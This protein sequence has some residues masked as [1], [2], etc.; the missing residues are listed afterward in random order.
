VLAHEGSRALVKADREDKKIFILVTG[1]EGTRRRLLSII[2]SHFDHIHSTITG[3]EVA[4]KVP[5]PDRPDVVLDYQDLLVFEAAGEIEPFIPGVRGRVNVKQL[6]EGVGRMGS[7]PEQDPI[8]KIEHHYHAPVA[9]ASNRGKVGA[10]AGTV[11][12][13]QIGTQNNASS[14]QLSKA[15]VMDMLAQIKA[16]I[17]ASDIPGEI[18]IAA[19]A[20]LQVAQ[21]ATEQETPKKGDRPGYP[22]EHG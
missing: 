6:L 4:G 9:V 8:T 15:D 18:K 2:R 21:K 16:L 11:Q 1:S 19:N 12:R 22:G 3:I 7:H 5:L 14:E 10:A 17:E 13:D 20:N